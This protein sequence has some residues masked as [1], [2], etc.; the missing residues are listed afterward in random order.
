[1]ERVIEM[2]ENSNKLTGLSERGNGILSDIIR[3]RRAL[4]KIPELKMDTPKTEAQIVEFLKE[5]GVDDIRSGVGGHGVCA[6]I[7]GELPGK[8]LAIRADCDGLPI[9]EETGLDFASAN[10]NMHACGHDAH[11][12][13]AL[14]AA[15]L[16]MEN[17][18]LLKGSVKFI[19]QPYEE[20]DGGAS[21][22]IEDGVLENPKVDAIIALHNHCTAD[23]DYIPGDILITNE[24][25][26]ANIY[27][28]DAVFYGTPA[29]IC[30]SRKAVNPV[31]VACD[32]VAQ[33]AKL[34]AI[35]ETVNAVTVINGGV[36]NNVIA[37]HC[38]VSGSI[39]AFDADV[40]KK[41]RDDVL[42]IINDTANKMGTK[43]EIN[44][45]IDLMGTEIDNSLYD[46]FRSVV[47]KIYTERGCIE[48]KSRDMIG[49]DF[50]RFANRVPAMYFMLHTKP[51]SE[52]Y[53]L[54]H[55]KFDVNEDVLHKGSIVFAGFAL[56]W[57]DNKEN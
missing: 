37:K 8:C 15:K 11:T 51:E 21:L 46:S 18:H 57:Q 53:P 40:H 33:I 25:V 5:I 39:R 6:L 43:S 48:L 47:N 4:H 20:G 16:L 31:H 10:G 19:F 29:H 30:H 28:Y 56:M 38:T 42:E 26:S 9:K 1:M 7:Q 14:G 23:T 52:C 27:A 24:P 35:E 54:H 41:M 32:A 13:I 34:P 50:A 2:V 3:W 22:M 44:T 49:E 36:R 17:R 12:A 45:T 55:P